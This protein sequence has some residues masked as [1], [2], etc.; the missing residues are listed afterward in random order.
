MR[1]RRKPPPAVTPLSLLDSAYDD[2]LRAL[3]R[4]RAASAAVHASRARLEASRRSWVASVER[5]ESDAREALATGDEA[6]ARSAAARCVP[7][8]ADIQ[9]A[10]EQLARFQDTEDDLAVARDIVAQ[11]LNALRRRREA[12]RG[13]R[14]TAA[15]LAAIRTDLAALDQGF[16]PVARVIEQQN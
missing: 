6:Q 9:A 13:M 10:D 14:S 15:A 7:L 16:E 1:F 3:E 11:Q 5:H 12:K 2:R 4:I 8:D